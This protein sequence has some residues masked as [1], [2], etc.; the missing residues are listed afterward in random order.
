MDFQIY[1]VFREKVIKDFVTEEIYFASGF[2]IANKKAWVNNK[3]NSSLS[4][5]YDV[6]HFK[7]KS[8]LKEEF[9]ELFRNSFI[10][11]YNYQFPIWKKSNLDKTIDKTYK[12]TPKV[13][14]Q[15][16]DWTTSIQS[17]FFLY[18]DG[19]NQNV[20]NFKTGPVLTIGSFKKKFFD[21]TKL[22]TNYNYV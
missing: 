16:L 19:S 7:S 11:Q 15:T 14:S 21:Y 8:K 1:N 4:L 13:I 9:R 20:M 17:G 22:S 3:Q 10:G 18:S 2:N 5:I 6:G 12:F